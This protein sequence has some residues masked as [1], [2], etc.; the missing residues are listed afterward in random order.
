MVRFLLIIDLVFLALSATPIALAQTPA[1]CPFHIFVSDD[2][3][4]EA[5]ARAT[6][7]AREQRKQLI[8]ENDRILQKPDGGN[9][10]VD[11]QKMDQNYIQILK[12]NNEFN[13]PPIGERP[14]W[15][16]RWSAERTRDEA[17]K[18]L[19]GLGPEIAK[20][21]KEW[22]ELNSRIEK[23]AA[24]LRNQKSRL[25]YLKVDGHALSE[26]EINA[27]PAVVRTASELEALRQRRKEVNHLRFDLSQTKRSLAGYLARVNNTLNEPP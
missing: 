24:T 19:E 7:A 3:E 9:N 26:E 27:N 20:Y 17:Q 14:T 6:W 5:I 12:L 1:D 11:R 10:S 13:L 2:V 15:Y 25:I 4:E 23:T 8:A 16:L 22:K 21:E 18:Q